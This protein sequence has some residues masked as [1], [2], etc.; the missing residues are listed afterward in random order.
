LSR[1]LEYNETA[2]ETAEEKLEDH[3]AGRAIDV[4]KRKH[5]APSFMFRK[6]LI[7]PR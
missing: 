1:Q 3:A 7:A 4:R 5:S 6:W 2:D